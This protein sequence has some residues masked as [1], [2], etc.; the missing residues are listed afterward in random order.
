MNYPEE[1][2]LA[3]QD[4]TIRKLTKQIAT[5]RYRLKQSDWIVCAEALRILDEAER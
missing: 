1:R 5:L 4:E 3:E 2:K